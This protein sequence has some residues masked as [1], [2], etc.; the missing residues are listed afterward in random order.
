LR[1]VWQFVGGTPVGHALVNRIQDDVSP[2]W[3]VE[4]RRV[5]ERRIVDDGGVATRFHLQKDLPYQ[6][7][8]AHPC[9]AHSKDVA[10]CGGAGQNQ[11]M[12]LVECSLDE[13]SFCELETNAVGTITGIRSSRGQKCRALEPWCFFALPSSLGT[14]R[15]PQRK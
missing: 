5:F 3:L 11:P 8:L 13:G 4:L 7:A 2:I 12:Y 15:H 1:N 10:R 6:G 9:I 14:L